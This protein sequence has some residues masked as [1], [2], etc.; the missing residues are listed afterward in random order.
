MIQ[1]P[2]VTVL[3][4]AY[5]AAVYI[6]EAIESV[7]AQTYKDFELLII[8]DGST[9]D[10]EAII[11]SYTDA[12][13]RV[14]SHSNIGLVG[15]LNRGLKEAQ[16]KWIARFDADD[17]CY[18][19]RLATQMEFL[20][21]HP[22]YVLTGSEA[23]YMDEAGNYLFTYHFKYYNDEDIRSSHFKE[24]PFIHSSVTFLKQAVIDAGGYDKDAITFEDHLL[25]SRLAH[26]GKMNNI[27]QPLI[28]VRFNPASVTID[29]KWRGKAFIDL[30]RRS[31]E[32]GSVNAADLETLKKILSE[33]NF[34]AYKRAA[35]ESMIGKKYLWNQ[36][37]PVKARRHLRAA[38]RLTPGKLE[39]YLLYIFSF[40]PERLI[41]SVYKK[42]KK[43]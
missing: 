10:T 33:Q 30:K 22:D 4:P 18:P 37:A 42:F 14:L 27:H 32:N 5:N 6:R 1:L 7:L 41:L 24:C 29:E 36:Y 15:T 9:D 17:V 40:M 25:W 8:N 23:D 38:I 3:M 21:Q 13:I 35:Y 12:R 31:I 11:R 34:T 2:Q 43:D 16:G 19:E 26:Y 28:K 39:P 20:Q